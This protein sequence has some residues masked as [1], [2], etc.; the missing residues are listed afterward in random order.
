MRTLF[1]DVDTQTDYV[2]PGGALYVKGAEEIVASLG[3]LTD[4]A[5]RTGARRGGSVD[6]HSPDDAELSSSPDWR[7]TFPPHCL[8]GTAG[9]AK[10]PATLPLSP[11]WVPSRPIRPDTLADQVRDHA[12]E[13]ILQKQ[14][15][16]VFSNPNAFAVLEALAPERVVV[17]GAALDLGGRA[18]IEGFLGM[19]DLEVWVVEDATRALHVAEV[20]A[21]LKRWRKHGARIVRTAEVVEGLA[22]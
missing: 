6:H 20:P 15:F 5:R 10:I 11:L 17:Y 22:L 19:G 18:A 3:R 12:G 14:S 1:W 7:E 4:H 21:L 2:E 16:D 8:A 13:V 9:A